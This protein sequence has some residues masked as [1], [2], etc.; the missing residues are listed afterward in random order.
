MAAQQTMRPES[1]YLTKAQYAAEAIRGRIRRGDLR[2]GSRL[3]LDALATQLQMSATP[4]REA[5]RSLEAEALVVNAPHR[6]IRVA[7]FSPLDAAELYDLRAN[8]ESY[9][10][11]LAVDHLTDP[12]MAHLDS[13]AA[14]HREALQREDTVAADRHNEE[15]HFT[16][17]R[18][19]NQQT[20]HLI[21]FISRLWNAFPWTTAWMVRGR[22]E[23]SAKEH[24]GVMTAIKARDRE[25]TGL[26]MSQHI[27]GGKQ[28]VIEHLAETD[29]GAGKA[30]SPPP[31]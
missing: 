13:L 3:D 24:D 17:Y 28:L 31:G 23:R 26:L 14:L 8:L 16:I 1:R 18:A 29:E 21:E 2:P 20:P 7:E 15:W 27:A 10:T 5:L 11:R 30:A 19:S 4:I 25:L 9:A 22:G 6:G 12:D